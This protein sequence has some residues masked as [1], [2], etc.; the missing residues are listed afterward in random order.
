[1]IKEIYVIDED[2]ELTETFA[3]MYKDEKHYKIKNVKEKDYKKELKNIPSLVIINEDTM[4][5]DI[6]EMCRYIRNDEDN[7]IT[8]IIVISSETDIDHRIS[9]A[10]EA[11]EYYFKR[12]LFENYMY[13][14]IK[15]LLRLLETNRRVSPL[16]GLPGNVQIHAEMKKRLAN[17][18]EFAVLYA[19]LDNFKAYND[20][21]GFVEGDEIIKY[22]AN[23]LLDS[24]HKLVKNDHF[25]GHIGGDDFIVIVS[26]CEYEKLCQEIIA[27][28]DNNITKFFT[29]ED[30]ERGYLEVANRRGVM[31]QFPITSISIGVVI[32]KEN[33]FKNILEIGEI[34]AQVK[35][36][37]KSIIGSSYLIDRRD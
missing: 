24:V 23:V 20:I 4:E 8:P 30:L 29:K 16:T 11:V 27:R 18:E 2:L 28:F 31:E 9:I 17:E 13:Y 7:A 25:V 6:I 34:G 3:R 1:M 19:D 22:T 14:T 37:A 21:Y 35:N 36:Y 10:K 32:N 12:P 26:Q 5:Q 15:N 33:K